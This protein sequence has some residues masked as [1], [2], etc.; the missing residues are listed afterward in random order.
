MDKF[1]DKH[2]YFYMFTGWLVLINIGLTIYSLFNYTFIV[3]DD[4][5]H[6]RAAYFVSLG[7]VPYRD[8]FEHHHP[9]LWYIL[10]P[11]MKILPHK[12]LI[13]LAVGRTISL[14]ISIFTFYYVFKIMKFENKQKVSL[15]IFIAV[16]FWTLASY[17]LFSSVKPDTY[18]RFCYFFGLY[19]LFMYF[20]DLNFK[21]L[22]ICTISFCIAFL[23]IQTILCQI[24]PLIFPFGYILYKHPDQ[25]KNFVKA[26][27]IPLIILGIVA[28]YFYINDALYLYYEKNWLVN[29]I[30]NRELLNTH[31]NAIYYIG[32]T[33]IFALIAIIVYLYRRHF[34][35]YTTTIVLLFCSE[36]IQRSILTV[37]LRYFIYLVIFAIILATPLLTSLLKR[38]ARIT[39]LIIFVITAVHS[40]YNNGY[41]YMSITQTNPHQYLS[42]RNLEH[43]KVLTQAFGIYHP[44][45][46]YYWGYAFVEAI[47]NAFFEGHRD[48]DVKQLVRQYKIR[49]LPNK[50][51]G[52]VRF[53]RQ[54]SETLTDEQKKIIE[55]HSL[56]EEIYDFYEPCE[57]TDCYELKEEFREQ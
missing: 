53:H 50:L 56:D 49:F 6:L 44:R 51:D 42:A 34:N 39:G 24:F 40:Y 48:Y 52:A 47:D 27:V 16:I 37:H 41:F 33:L 19:H 54:F 28:C 46:S 43:E 22:Q 38:Y 26:T 15:L 30:L 20:R 29:R 57:N 12:T 14:L 8:F 7:D 10:A 32:D 23:F 4:L 45:L 31:T 9:L 25:M 21:N 55:N 35:T 11:L 1:V 2:F 17:T 13:T 18:A 5:E 3:G 36:L